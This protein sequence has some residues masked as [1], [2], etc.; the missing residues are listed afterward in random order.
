M[1]V[2]RTADDADASSEEVSNLC[3]SIRK[4]ISRKQALR[5]EVHE[6]QEE[7]RRLTE[8]LQ[9]ANQRVADLEMKA[10]PGFGG[11]G[12]HLEGAVEDGTGD[13]V[14]REC[15]TALEGELRRKSLRAVELHRRVHWLESQLG[16]Q[17]QVNDDRVAGVQTALRE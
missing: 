14:W 15:V 17:L 5:D 2:L 13:S 16:Q 9:C 3:Q 4:A 10:V 7:V 6:Q 8:A 11:G 1:R 12:A